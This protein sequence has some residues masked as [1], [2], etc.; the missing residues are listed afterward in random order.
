MSLNSKEWVAKCRNSGRVSLILY[1][2]GILQG[3]VA[4][5]STQVVIDYNYDELNRL[6]T[7]ARGDGPIVTYV[8]DEVSN[9]TSRAIHNS[10]DT[11]GDSLGD[12]ADTDDDNDSIP[13][14]VEVANFL[15]PLNA[16]DA[17]GDR[18]GDGISNLDEY[19]LGFDIN[20]WQGDI[21]ND[22]AVTLA[23]VVLLKRIV[24]DKETA[25]QDQQL[26]GHGDLNLNGKLDVG[27]VVIMERIYLGL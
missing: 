10:P 14:T 1:L 25:R 27:D 5:A 11:D 21:N 7:V 26:P 8:Y 23:D 16:S 22:D 24:L 2:I 18:D 15:N 9:L 20:H 17:A 12:F 6:T 4:S 13:D 19:L 3:P